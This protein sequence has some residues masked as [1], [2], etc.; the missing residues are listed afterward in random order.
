MTTAAALADEL[1][2]SRDD[3][4]VVLAQLGEP[5]VSRWITS[6]QADDVR[7]VLYPDRVRV[8]R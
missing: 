5:R 1:G 7:A 6:R 2:V 4:L 8:A 3:A